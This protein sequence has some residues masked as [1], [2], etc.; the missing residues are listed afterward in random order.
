MYEKKGLAVDFLRFRAGA[1]LRI[2][3]IIDYFLKMR[4]Q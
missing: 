2:F 3:Q 1:S 4:Q